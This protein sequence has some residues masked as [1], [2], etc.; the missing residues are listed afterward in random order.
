MV[1]IVGRALSGAAI[2]G[3]QVTRNIAAQ[4]QAEKDRQA[5]QWMIEADRAW[6]ERQTERG[7]EEGR[8]KEERQAEREG[9]KA[10][11]EAARRAEETAAKH[12]LDKE[13]ISLRNRGTIEAAKIRSSGKSSKA[14]KAETPAAI[15]KAIE[16]T[17]RSIFDLETK[18]DMSPNPEVI[19]REIG[20]RSAEVRKLNTKLEA[21]TSGAGKQVGAPKPV[22]PPELNLT[23]LNF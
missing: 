10:E 13:K 4:E 12:E 14:D 16:S 18:R 11:R 8:A 5:K 7:Y 23:G 17:Q 9:L 21:L 3:R 20:R 19:D 2:G 22:A 1:G 6:Q 15:E